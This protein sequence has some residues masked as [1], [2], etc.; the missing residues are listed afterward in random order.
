MAHKQRLKFLASQIRMLSHV[1]KVKPSPEVNQ[2]VKL[3]GFNMAYVASD[4]GYCGTAGCIAGHACQIFG[5]PSRRAYSMA[6]AAFVLGMDRWAAEDLFLGPD[7][8]RM[9]DITPAAAADACER[10]AAGEKPWPETI[11]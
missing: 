9:E 10:V 1:R 5:F 3:M 7:S 6:N 11:D 8:D 2:P 4:S